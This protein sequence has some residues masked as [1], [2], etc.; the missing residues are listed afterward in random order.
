M[1]SDTK[2]AIR[3]ITQSDSPFESWDPSASRNWVDS[4]A[5]V[6][7]W[8]W[9]DAWKWTVPGDY[10]F[11]TQARSYQTTVTACD[12]LPIKMASAVHVAG[13]L[14]KD[15]E[16]MVA[17]S[18]TVIRVP[19]STS[20]S[21]FVRNTETT[22]AAN[23][24][25][26]K[27]PMV[28]LDGYPMQLPPRELE[29]R[30]YASLIFS[31]VLNADGTLQADMY[32]T[33]NQSGSTEA[34]MPA[35]PTV[36]DGAWARYAA[37]MTTSGA[38]VVT[39]LSVFADLS[40]TSGGAYKDMMDISIKAPDY[41]A[42]KDGSV[43]FRHDEAR[44]LPNR[45]IQNWIA[46]LGSTLVPPLNQTGLGAGMQFRFYVIR[47]YKTGYLRSFSNIDGENCEAVNNIGYTYA[48]PKPYRTVHGLIGL[49]DGT[50][51]VPDNVVQALHTQSQLAA[52]LSYAIA[53][54]SQQQY[55]HLWL[56]TTYGHG[57]TLSV[58]RENDANLCALI[59]ASNEQALRL[60]IRQMALA[61][62]DIRDAPFAW[63]IAK[64]KH[65]LNPVLN[66]NHP[67]QEIPWYAAYAFNYISQYYQDV[68]YSKLKRGVTEYQQFLGELRK[69]D[70][71]AFQDGDQA[72]QP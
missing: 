71:E 33:A 21:G 61:G 50:I 8:K 52:L 11:S 24:V 37:H 54:V 39:Q 40:A 41:R 38:L 25:D 30:S 31:P 68:D 55:Y 16:T 67:D 57:T 12:Q 28:W 9:F 34:A 44:I 70:P 10:V 15:L 3:T 56:A 47:A 6:D 58:L 51:L 35:Q 27:L 14:G 18:L 49:Q 32:G 66:S 69:T 48:N 72:A 20:V 45:S 29:S 17:K 60:G 4:R 13:V 53:S 43:R 5:W 62:Y 26:G 36:P 1:A 2:C 64:E 42:G 7:S 65:V 19:P 63:A 23:G 22:G 46:A 59:T